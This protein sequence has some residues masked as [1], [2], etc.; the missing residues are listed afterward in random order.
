MKEII[1]YVLLLMILYDFSLH[2]LELIIGSECA[3]KIKYYWPKFET[4]GKFDRK[5]Y[6]KFWICYWGAALILL[7]VYLLF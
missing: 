5:K 7:V 1:L 6:T 4:K 2:L 3:R